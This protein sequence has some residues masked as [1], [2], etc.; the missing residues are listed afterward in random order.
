MSGTQQDNNKAS[1]LRAAE[2]LFVKR[3]IDSVDHNFAAD[4]AYHN[5]R[6][7]AADKAQAI[8]ARESL[9]RFYTGFFAGFP[10]MKPDVQH[11]L[12]DGDKVSCF[13]IWKGTHSGAFMGLPPT[14]LA[15]TVRVANVFRM[16]D[17]KI[18][19][20]W[21]ILNE[22]DL[23]PVFAAAAKLTGAPK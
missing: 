4:F 1:F 6:R 10:D 11:V 8:T 21:D 9:K 17:G 23:A 12:A 20:H 18:A 22:A 5:D 19:E 14:N 13:L 2:E 15:V 7:N 3:D 16:A